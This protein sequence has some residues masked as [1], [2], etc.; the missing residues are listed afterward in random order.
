MTSVSFWEIEDVGQEAITIAEGL[1]DRW[2]AINRPSGDQV[3]SLS[4]TEPVVRR[5][6]PLPSAFMT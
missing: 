6:M 4:M 1:T 2:N 3:G 5:S